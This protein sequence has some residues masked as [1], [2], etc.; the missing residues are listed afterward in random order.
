MN[1]PAGPVLFDIQATQSVD[2][3]HRGIPRY[4][5]ELALA[6]EETVPDAVGAYLINPDRALPEAAERLV[7]TGKLRSS[8]DVDWAS[9]GLL[10]I[11]SPL[12]MTVRPHR[13]LPPAARRAAVPRLV[14][15]YDL[16]PY[17]MPDYYLEDP[18]LRRRYLARLQMVRTAAG[19]LTLSEATRR[20]VVEHLG[21][22]PR[23]VFVVGSGTGPQFVPPTS[24]H[25]AA[26]AAAAAVPGLRP[27]YVFYI[28]SYEKRKNLEPLLEAWS[29]LPKQVRANWQLALCCPLKPSELRH[30][31]YRAGQMGVADEVCFTG[32]V[33]DDVL[34]LLHQGADLFVF[35]SL[36]EGYGLPVAEALAC[37]A[38]VLAANASSLP[39]IVGP[40]ALF[41]PTDTAA[42]AAAIERGLTDD[43]LRARLLAAAG[44][45]PTTWAEVATATAA[46]YDLVLT[47]KLSVPG[48]RRPAPAGAR[49][50]ASG[51]RP[52]IALAGP[53]PPDGG[54]KARWSY[55]LAE[56]LASRADVH[57]FADRPSDATRELRD[58]EAPPGVP[59]HP[60]AALETVEEHGGTFDAVVYSVAAD[61]HHTG[62]L[63]ALRRR[64]DGIVVAHDVHLA[65]L[66][67]HAARSG[68]LSG[69]A[70][71]AAGLGGIIAAAY[72]DAVP[73]GLGE[74]NRLGAADAR[75]RGVLLSRDVLARSRRFLVTSEIDATLARLD[76][77]PADRS[78]VE[79]VDGDPYRLADALVASITQRRPPS[80]WRP[81]PAGGGVVFD[82]QATQSVDQRHRGISR[83]VFELASAVEEAAPESVRAY[84]LNP[85]LTL[86]EAAE[87]LAATG[88]L[89]FSDDVDW[90][91]VQLLH[92]PSLFEMGVPLSRLLPPEARAAGVPWVITFHDLIPHLMPESYLE[93]A[94]RRR[95]YRAR[96][97]LVK[98][99]TA[100]LTN[101]GATRADAIGHLG[102]DP[103][104]VF[105][106]GTGTGAHFVPPDSRSRV[107]AAAAAAVPGLRPPFVFYVGNYEKRK[108]LEPLLDAWSRLG[109]ELRNRYQLVVCGAANPLERNHLLQRAKRMGL[110]DDVLLTGF[111]PDE[112]LLWLHQSAE[113]FV[114]PSLYEG[115]GLPV[116]EALA[117][118]T[119]VLAANSSSLPEIVGPDALF[120]PGDPVAMAAA[121]E[122]GLT[123]ENLR[124]RLLAAAGRPPT[125][126]REVAE[127]TVA[128]YD[129]VLSG[130]LPA[131]PRAP[132]RPWR[133]AFVSP[134][135][136]DGG[137]V[138]AWNYRL[139][140]E[141]RRF[142]KIEAFA[143]R[144]VG[145]GMRRGTAGDGPA[146]RRRPEAPEGVAVHPLGSFD[147]VENLSG[148]FDAI[149]YSLADDEH[150]TGSLAALRRRSGVVLAHDVRLARLYG[151]AARSGALPSGLAET[152]RRAYGEAIPPWLGEGG[153]VSDDEARRQGVLM[154]RD[155]V[156]MAE[157]F[158]VLSTAAAE[159]ALLDI[160]AADR[161][162]VSVLPGGEASLPEV[163]EALYGLLAE[164]ASLVPSGL[165][166]SGPG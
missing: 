27:P 93:D 92:T 145:D 91:R 5:L 119:A 159:L 130:G 157:R 132:R 51:G 24:R 117:C 85:D 49:H 77:F 105:V 96:L 50:V 149:V 60:I 4:V 163:A 10:H 151:H 6:L 87:R 20:D 57:A 110:G 39:E 29:R 40:E 137:P 141:L 62:S 52:R 12:E 42:M 122:A 82:L 68:A 34:L 54:P 8:D 46:V 35:P 3:R 72:G 158:V 45:P 48:E 114:F 89:R 125:T 17:L 111:V 165:V 139:L 65:G 80:D 73:P 55:R 164:P 104:R 118:G 116:A 150:H 112:V 126:W 109:R 155:V 136:P 1:R 124:R 74:S 133:L 148:R 115:Y 95:H 84:L 58:P 15:F 135:P 2:Q 154:V 147:A 70:R 66:Y 128:T 32:F 59:I 7:A 47:G 76:A 25:E 153:E 28:G 9:A 36:Y 156:A 81:A 21:L 13:Q 43:A 61:D 30:L 160:A 162:K 31:E 121:I 22:D 131:P 94:G 144:G 71:E 75:R 134:L 98:M 97:Q 16:I 69:P 166:P 113:L 99:A 53:F 19:V 79:V 56:E 44:R 88:K 101:S 107:A 64:R 127:A 123:D 140:E 129:R 11:A 26:A 102:L 23:R 38:P 41:D 143:D 14:T 83:Y 67:E 78:K 33:T 152:F 37:G 161:P 120:D 138:A 63:E 108:N 103:G 106:A 90:A 100:V 146:E 18:G 86:P 142:G